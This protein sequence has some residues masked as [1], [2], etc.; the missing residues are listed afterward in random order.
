MLPA[1]PPRG[2]RSGGGAR[3]TSSPLFR[4]ETMPAPLGLLRGLRGVIGPSS[5]AYP[6]PPFAEAVAAAEAGERP[7]KERGVSG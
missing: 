4:A 3:M 1:L 7:L 6:P 5:S 2:E